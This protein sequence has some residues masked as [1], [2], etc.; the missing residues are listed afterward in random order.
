MTRLFLAILAAISLWTVSASGALAHGLLVSV[1]GDGET[2]AGRVYYSNG[3]PGVGE[4]VEMQDLT[5]PAAAPVPGV[6][7]GP[8]G[9]FSFA[10]RPG[11]SYR[12][13]VT[14]DEGHQVRSD[15]TLAPDARGRFVEDA[16]DAAVG[17]GGAGG[18]PPAWMLIGGLL[19][20]SLI[21]AWWLRRR[22][23]GRAEPAKSANPG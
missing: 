3:E 22:Q 10:G 18:L 15:I 5:D 23:A 4:W 7:V 21:P 9:A 13:T 6:S 19:M 14:G 16:A 1:R 8:D 2:V 20:L 11:H 12:V 17:E